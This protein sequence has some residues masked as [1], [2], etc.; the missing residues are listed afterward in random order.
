M[1]QADEAEEMTAMSSPESY[2]SFM[3]TPL[4]NRN[5]GAKNDADE[6]TDSSGL[7][8]NID[9]HKQNKCDVVIQY[10]ILMVM[11]FLASFFA[12]LMGHAMAT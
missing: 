7:S 8:S 9:D 1:A 3:D 2:P 10:C 11:I 5:Q 4:I 12:F 6:L